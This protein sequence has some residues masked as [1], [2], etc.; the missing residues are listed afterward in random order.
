MD[1]VLIELSDS[2]AENWSVFGISI[3]KDF[4]KELVRF[5]KDFAKDFTKD[6]AKEWVG[7]PFLSEIAK[8]KIL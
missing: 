5:G 3:A 1:S 6:F 2:D 4:A 8:A 7:M